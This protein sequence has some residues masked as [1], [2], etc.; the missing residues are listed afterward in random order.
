V[1]PAKST[2]R[3]V[4][5]QGSIADALDHRRVAKDGWRAGEVV[6]ESNSGAKKNR[7]DVDVDFVE[8]ASIQTLLDGVSAVDPNRLPGGGACVVLD[9]VSASP[10]S[11]LNETL[12]RRLAGP[13]APHESGGTFAERSYQRR[14][15]LIHDDAS[16]SSAKQSYPR[17]T[18][19]SAAKQGCPRKNKLVQADPKLSGGKQA[20]PGR[21]RLICR[22]SRSSRKKQTCLRRN[23]VIHGKTSSS[24]PK[25]GYS[26]E[27][28][29]IQDFSDRS[30][31]PSPSRPFPLLP[32]QGRAIPALLY[33]E[34]CRRAVFLTAGPTSDSLKV[35]EGNSGQ[36][37]N[38]PGSLR[39]LA[40]FGRRLT[41]RR[42]IDN[43][44]T[45][46]KPE[47][48]CRQSPGSQSGRR[49]LFRGS[50]DGGKDLVEPKGIE[51]STS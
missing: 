38:K 8:E 34:S 1:F 13:Y 32:V 27:N 36:G 45:A 21:S 48:L 37:G 44:F 49:C 40:G 47:G 23:K 46:E 3:L 15:K 33:I 17:R 7:R 43:R 51:P 35:M 14:R 39:I 31:F 24:V 25:Q 9:N 16:L 5:P 42:F 50:D 30:T 19:L 10:T 12:V 6:E 29:L 2:T 26:R 4:G 18:R 22:D 11:L 20:H 41:C 28:K